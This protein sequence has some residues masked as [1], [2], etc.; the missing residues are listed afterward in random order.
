MEIDFNTFAQLIILLFILF[1]GVELILRLKGRIPVKKETEKSV[2][3]P[4]GM[5]YISDPELGFSHQEGE[6]Q[7][8]IHGRFNF[9][10]RH[11]KQGHRITGVNAGGSAITEKPRI[12]IFGC[13]YTYGWLLNDND[14]Y[15]W[16]LQEKLK[17]YE[18][19]NFAVSGYGTLQPYLQ[20][21]KALKHHEPP[22]IVIL[23]YCSFHE[24]RNTIERKWKKEHSYIDRDI[25]FKVP[26]ARFDKS[27]KLVFDFD[28]MYYR[29]FPF[30]E[31]SAI[32]KVIEN[33]YNIWHDRK[34]NSRKVTHEIL[35]RLNELCIE[36]GTL[37]ILA[38][39][40][41]GMGTKETL[42]NC[43]KLGMTTVDISVD[44]SPQSPENYHYPFDSHPS[45]LAN[46]KYAD[47]LHLFLNQKKLVTHVDTK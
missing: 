32:M 23:G 29:G 33:R 2:I 17:N 10:A 47:K 34:L 4:E 35:G 7:F 19:T 22:E 27:G 41:E 37:F 3:K 6:Y 5:F 42:R 31:S 44:R 8:E 45:A 28:S 26:C 12:W 46:Q 16:L 38:G 14:T 13:S 25:P 43:E 9:K 40:H 24:K 39:L 11:N 15:P 36:S 30:S 18:I 1:V 21:K 20:L